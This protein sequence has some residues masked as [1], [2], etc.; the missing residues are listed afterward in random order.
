M[1]SEL[2]MDEYLYAH[3]IYY[4]PDLNIMF[5]QCGFMIFDIFD[6]IDP[7]TLFLFK[8]KKV[9]VSTYDKHGNPV[10]LFYEGMN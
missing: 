4:D 5:D 3:R 9:D 6:I 8:H 1:L 7:N 2:T 10:I